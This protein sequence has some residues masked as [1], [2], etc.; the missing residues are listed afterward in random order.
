MHE[1]DILGQEK[2]GTSNEKGKEVVGDGKGS[3]VVFQHGGGNEGDQRSTA[4]VAKTASR[5][6]LYMMREE[7]KAVVTK[8]VAVTSKALLKGSDL[9]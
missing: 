9:M 5:I 4:A 6:A 3:T 8:M 1:K 7:M 2:E